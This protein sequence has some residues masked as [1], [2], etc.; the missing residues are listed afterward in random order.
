MALSWIWLLAICCFLTQR[1]RSQF[2]L[3]RISTAWTLSSSALVSVLLLFLSLRS[4][5]SSHCVISPE[6]YWGCW[7]SS[8]MFSYTMLSTSP[9]FCYPDWPRRFF[10]R[11]PSFLSEVLPFTSSELQPST[12][13]VYP[14]ST[15]RQATQNVTKP[16]K[17]RLKHK[18]AAIFA[19]LY[20]VEQFFM[21][22]SHF[23]TKVGGFLYK[24]IFFFP[25]FSSELGESLKSLNPPWVA[26]VVAAQSESTVIVSQKTRSQLKQQNKIKII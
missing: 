5:F 7:S 18:L 3:C 14:K 8:G 23:I 4:A 13:C 25:A 17:L 10:A 12:S 26:A 20:I 16:S 22:Y 6:S 21:P 15:E 2:S 1:G 19:I 9:L 11:F 24:E